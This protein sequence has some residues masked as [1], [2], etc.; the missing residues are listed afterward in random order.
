MAFHAP[1]SGSAG[2][3]ATA[4][5]LAVSAAHAES[6]RDNLLGRYIA[7]VACSACHQVRPGGL[8]PDPHPDDD[9]RAIGVGP[10][11][12]EIAATYGRDPAGLRGS[13]KE[14]HYPMPEPAIGANDLDSVIGY[15]LQLGARSS[16]SR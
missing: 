13:L 5:L 16:D 6:A 3:A 2:I 7:E 12:L 4:I 8:A 9:N 1:L 14:A 10:S 11:F 15:I